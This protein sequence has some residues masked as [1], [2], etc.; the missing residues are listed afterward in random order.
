MP[1][2]KR[3]FWNTIQ[4]NNEVADVTEIDIT[5]NF[6]KTVVNSVLN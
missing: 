3:V 4:T 1:E 6:E 5:E 2:P